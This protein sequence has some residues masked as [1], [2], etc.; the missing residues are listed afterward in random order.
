MD[1]T[2]I[3]NHGFLKL[4]EFSL[5]NKN[6]SISQAC[7]TTGL[8]PKQFNFA[9]HEIF[10]LNGAQDGYVQEN[11]MQSWEL[12]PATYFNYLQYLE[13]KHS[14]ETSQKSTK[15]AIGAIIVSGVLALASLIVSINANT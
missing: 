7:E 3:E 8:S 5:E 11:E 14:I 6:F 13:F 2:K 1:I 15:L 12:S 4:I 9:K 10:V